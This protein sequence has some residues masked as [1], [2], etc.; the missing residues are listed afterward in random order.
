MMNQFSAKRNVR[1]WDA[2]RTEVAGFYQYGT[3]DGHGNVTRTGMTVAELY[4]CLGWCFQNPAEFILMN[5]SGTILDPVAEQADLVPPDNYFVISTGT[6]I[7]CH[8]TIDVR[9]SRERAGGYSQP[10]SC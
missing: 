6:Y 8:Y 5:E 3:K 2:D 7:P 4:Q 1:I 10:R 9:R